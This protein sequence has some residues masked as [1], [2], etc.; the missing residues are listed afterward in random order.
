MT[1]KE[2]FLA[3]EPFSITTQNSSLIAIKSVFKLRHSDF[4]VLIPSDGGRPI[5]QGVV[6]IK[7]NHIEVI[8]SFM[9]QLV[10]QVVPFSE[11]VFEQP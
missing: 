4:I 10:S 3:G 11:M 7:E 1:Q 5:Y 8:G 2:R 6:Y 9:T